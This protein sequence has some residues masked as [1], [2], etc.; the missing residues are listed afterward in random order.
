MKR[1]MRFLALLAG[2][3]GVAVYFVLAPTLPAQGVTNAPP[4][5]TG[6][7][8]ADRA[9]EE[10]VQSL[11][12]AQ[13]PA[14]WQTTEP[15][16]EQVA[17]FEKHNGEKAGLA[18]DKARAFYTQYPNH[19]KAA[20]ARQL[21]YQLLNVAVQ[22]GN[23]ARK[24]G[25]LAVEE[26]RL[27]DPATSEDE[28]FEVRLRQAMRPFM[29]LPEGDKTAALAELEKTTRAL[30]K[31][32]PTR[33]EVFEVLL[34]LAQANLEDNHPEKS[35]ALAKEVAEGAT[36]E[37]RTSA[38]GL[39]HRLDRLGQ[40]LKLKFRTP[41]GDD[42]DL[43]KLRG[44]VVLVDFWATWCAP[45]RA[46]LPEVKAAY[47]KYRAKGFEIVGIS[48]DQNKETLQKFVADQNMTWPQYFDGRGWE[49]KWGREFEIT[50]IPAMWLVDKKGTLRELN[51]RENLTA[52]VEKLLGEK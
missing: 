2:V 37:A 35:R 15:S 34:L 1:C 14:E 4:A 39:L 21:E 24:P 40:P 6:A 20:Q 5:G 29:R 19:A 48:F 22:L 28:R 44:K 33:P 27:K 38:E 46:A 50:A 36:G 52:K 49:N 26:A 8:A 51:A 43:E 30:Q 47:K 18:A 11:P 42:F 13:P 23:T 7:T 41:E 12:D 25:L 17:Q 16:R 31:E 9:W 32:F 10:L 45:C 3:A